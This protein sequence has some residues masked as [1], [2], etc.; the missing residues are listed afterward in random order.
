MLQSKVPAVND[1]EDKRGR[2]G[3]TPSFDNHAPKQAAI[4]L[5]FHQPAAHQ[6]R[7]HYL[8]RTAEEGLGEGWET[9][10]NERGGDRSG[11]GATTFL[12]Q[13]RQQRLD[14]R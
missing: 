3:N 1:I 4:R 9:L 5:A 14:L 12:T 6:A 2:P 10:G 8:C 11:L 13:V 7:S